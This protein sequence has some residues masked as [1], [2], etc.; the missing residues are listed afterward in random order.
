MEMKIGSVRPTKNSPVLPGGAVLVCN[1]H[2]KFRFWPKNN[3]LDFYEK[4]HPKFQF[5]EQTINFWLAIFF[6]NLFLFRSWNGG[7]YGL[8]SHFWDK[9]RRW[10]YCRFTFGHTRCIWWR[11]WCKGRHF[12]IFP[13]DHDFQVNFLKKVHE[14]CPLKS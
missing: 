14:K 2:Q 11:F 9:I 12:N 13:F 7:Y 1:F 4:N 5:F 3:N 6:D 8:E 10:R